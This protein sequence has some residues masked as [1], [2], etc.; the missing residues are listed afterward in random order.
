MSENLRGVA[1]SN[2]LA[3]VPNSA[4]EIL[5]VLDRPTVQIGIAYA[6]ILA[7]LNQL[8]LKS[9]NLSSVCT[10]WTGIPKWLGHMEIFLKQ[11]AQYG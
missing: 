11:I 6:H 5:R 8:P 4:P 1:L 2:H 7:L 9:S 10:L 3:K